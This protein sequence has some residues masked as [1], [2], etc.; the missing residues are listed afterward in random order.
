M[1]LLFVS[2]PEI[3][4]A[5]TPLVLFLGFTATLLYVIYKLVDRWVDRMVN[6][7][8]EQNALLAKLL[9]NMEK[10]NVSEGA[11]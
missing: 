3:I 4:L 10:K 9:D 1:T 8:R 5:L 7:R 6:V 2:L 11:K